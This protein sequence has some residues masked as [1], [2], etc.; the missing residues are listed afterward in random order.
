[1]QS[2]SVFKRCDLPCINQWRFNVSGSGIEKPECPENVVTNSLGKEISYESF[3]AVVDLINSMY[4]KLADRRSAMW[5]KIAASVLL[6]CA[7]FGFRQG[8]VG[9]GLD[10]E[11]GSCH[12]RYVAAT[13]G[14][15]RK[16]RRGMGE[17]TTRIWNF[18][19]K[20]K[21]ILNKKIV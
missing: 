6:R 2:N 3:I 19:N 1:M 17:S 7:L 4:K 18:Y 10:L 16:T 8:E 13:T 20:E 12:L 5:L 9:T 14:T 11:G 21:Q 15:C